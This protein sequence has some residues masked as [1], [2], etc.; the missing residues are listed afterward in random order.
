L[1]T[2]REPYVPPDYQEDVKMKGSFGSGGSGGTSGYKVARMQFVL[3][4]YN[5][6]GQFLGQGLAPAFTTKQRV[7]RFACF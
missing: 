4:T 6:H 3:A 1:Q 5:L 2:K 7:S